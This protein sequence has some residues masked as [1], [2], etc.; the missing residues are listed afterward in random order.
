MSLRLPISALLL[1]TLTAWRAA[2]PPW[3]ASGPSPD[4]PGHG[5][6]AYK[7]VTDGTRSFR[8]VDPMPWG[9]ANRRVSPPGTAETPPV[10]DQPA[11]PKPD[12]APAAPA[13]PQ[14]HIHEGH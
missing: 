10:T 5:R 12:A 13:A 6:G 3:P 2:D 1:V 4:E 7:S 8:P 9:D 11:L 14:M